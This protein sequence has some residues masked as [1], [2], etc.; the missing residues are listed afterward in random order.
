M[1]FSKYTIKE[2]AEVLG[3]DLYGNSLNN[4]SFIS[5]DSRSLEL[6]ENTL[7]FC[8]TGT[9]NDAHDF[10]SEIQEK[11]VTCFVVSKLSAEQKEATNNITFLLV[12]DVLTAFQKLATYH[13][14]K[15]NKPVIGITG[16]NGKTIVKEW[17][18]QLLSEFGTVIRSPKSY[19]SQVGVPL[20][21]WLLNNDADYGIIEA[22]ISKPG[23][24]ENLEG[25]VKPDIG[26]FTCIGQAHQEGF[27]NIKEKI[28]EKL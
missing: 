14:K 15:F 2:V 21:V 22:G 17:L 8:L 16:S 5:I 18:A 6:N 10:I 24:M 19:N 25:I 7:F 26:I 27:S 20:S 1:T 3:A 11:G 13:R 28:I 12:P 9:R 23:E 4:I